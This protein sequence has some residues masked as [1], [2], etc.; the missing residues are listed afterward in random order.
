M[1]T[2]T[3]DRDFDL[4]AIIIKSLYYGLFIN[5][6]IPM[7]IL[8][9]CYYFETHGQLDNRLGLAA[10]TWF[11]VFAVA[12]LIQAAVA[13]WYRTKL[14]SRPMI[15]NLVRVEQDIKEQLLKR[16]RPVFVMVAAICLWGVAYYLLTGRFNE[17]LAFIVFSFVVFQFIR[18]RYGSV[19]KLIEKQIAMAERGE[20][21][22]SQ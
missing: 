14:L 12:A 8:L 19:Q 3:N 10:A 2:D 17:G 4:P 11:Y 9:I 15:T 5:I 18:P 20:L 21:L 7:A 6:L 13:L 1:N 22:R 16:S